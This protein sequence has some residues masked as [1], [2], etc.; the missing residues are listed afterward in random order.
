[1]EVR[2]GVGVV[3]GKGSKHLTDKAAKI[4]KVLRTT[5]RTPG[6]LDRKEFFWV[7]SVSLARLSG[8][9]TMCGWRTWRCIAG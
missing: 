3:S 8:R 9:D 5:S 1:M 4:R 7:T 6:P 2:E